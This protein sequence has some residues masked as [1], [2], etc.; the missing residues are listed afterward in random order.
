ML[1]IM[2]KST[3][4]RFPLVAAAVLAVAML[5]SACGAFDAHAAEPDAKN[6][7]CCTSFDDGAIAKRADAGLPGTGG[8]APLLPPAF[9][10][11]PV[12]APQPLVVAVTAKVLPQISFHAR[13]ARILR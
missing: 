3:L 2:G 10:H 1:E 4:R 8:E 13:S 12:W 7:V 9:T 6:D 5:L 11:V